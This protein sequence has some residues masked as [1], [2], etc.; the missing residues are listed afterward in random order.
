MR[1]ASYRQ[2]IL[3]EIAQAAERKD[4][5]VLNHLIQQRIQVDRELVNLSRK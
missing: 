4:D 2:K 5:E 3:T 1:L